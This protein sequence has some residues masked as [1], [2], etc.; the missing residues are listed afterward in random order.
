MQEKNKAITDSE[1]TIQELRMSVN[2]LQTQI[3]VNK[4][5]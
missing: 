5:A 3:N 1:K 2:Y 4:N